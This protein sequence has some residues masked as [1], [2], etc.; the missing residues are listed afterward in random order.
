MGLYVICYKLHGLQIHLV[1]HITVFLQYGM[2]TCISCTMESVYYGQLRTN[3]KQPVYQVDLIF[4]VSL[5]DKASF[6]TIAK[7]VDYAGVLII[8]CPD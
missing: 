4:W 8:R 3:H 5:Y 2:L 1:Q 6:G 7:C